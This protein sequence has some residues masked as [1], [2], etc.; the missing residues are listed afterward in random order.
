MHGFEVMKW[1]DVRKNRR[2]MYSGIVRNVRELE[3]K[4]EEIAEKTVKK[5]VDK[6]MIVRYTL[7]IPCDTEHDP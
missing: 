4:S 6:R 2:R 1:S 5:G 7:I 3:S